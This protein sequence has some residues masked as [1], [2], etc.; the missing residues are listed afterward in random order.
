[1]SKKLTIVTSILCVLVLFVGVINIIT[2]QNQTKALQNQTKSRLVSVYSSIGL[3]GDKLD[4]SINLTNKSDKNIFVQSVQPLV[5]EK[6][7]NRILSKEMV[8]TVN[9][10]I[11]PNKA[12]A[13]TGVIIVNTKGLKDMV[14]LVPFITDIKVIST[15]TVS[16][17]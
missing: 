4:Y 5:N 12:I 15:E 10:E 2:V 17:K 8:I 6:L 7:K 13:I 16:L 1:M 3:G 14:K 11:K 9:K